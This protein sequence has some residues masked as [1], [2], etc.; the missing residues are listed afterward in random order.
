MGL[1]FTDSQQPHYPPPDSFREDP[2]YYDQERD[3]WV[4]L[5]PRYSY[6]VDVEYTPRAPLA[7]AP[8]QVEQWRIGIV[9]NVIYERI[10]VEYFD[11]EPYTVT[12]TRPALDIGSEAYRPFYNE[13]YTVNIRIP[14]RIAGIDQ[15][16]EDRVSVVAVHEVLYG[17]RGL[18]LLYDPWAP[19]GY[20]PLPNQILRLRMEDRPAHALRNWNNND[21]ARAERVMVM[22][23]W[24]IAMDMTSRSVVLGFSP[25]FTLVAWMQLARRGL[26]SIQPRPTWGAYSR[27]G[28]HTR[29][30]ESHEQVER[31]QRRDGSIQPQPARGGSPA[32]LLTGTSANER[33][34]S[35]LQANNL[36]PSRREAER[37]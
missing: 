21:L 27:T 13:P 37:P 9:Q 3:A 28:A 19:D 22:R 24:I 20:A 36:L 33:G 14:L 15:I 25:Q 18:G 10:L 12:W 17:P 35:W 23:F 16:L 26:R 32:P 8:R 34:L 2:P 30:I 7:R 11:Q 5:L 4:Q 29:I 1:H 6:E 31:L